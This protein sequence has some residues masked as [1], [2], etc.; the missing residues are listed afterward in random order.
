MIAAR[1]LGHD[2]EG[3][4]TPLHLFLRLAQIGDRS[5]QQPHGVSR[6]VNPAAAVVVYEQPVVGRF[7]LR[8]RPGG[9]N[10]WKSPMR[11]P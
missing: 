4:V 7:Q 10:A 3:P 6:I 9:I 8:P 5:L 1:V 11:P 2:R